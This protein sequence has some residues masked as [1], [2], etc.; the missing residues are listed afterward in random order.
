[1]QINSSTNGHAELTEAEVSSAALADEHPGVRRAVELVGQI[2]TGSVA[3]RGFNGF[4]HT[5]LGLSASDLACSERDLSSV[6]HVTVGLALAALIERYDPQIGPS[7]EHEAP[8]WGHVKIG[9]QQFT[10]PRCLA[11]YF[12]AGTMA[13][14]PMVVR[15]TS[16]RITGN[17]QLQVYTR[18]ADRAH[19]AAAIETI[20]TDADGP[21]NLFRNKALT[22]TAKY[23]GD[24][25]FQVADLPAVTRSDV[26]VPE[27]VW[28]E[29]DLNI[30]AVTTQRE[31]MT[32]LGMGL[33]RGV[34]LAG[35]PGVGKTAISQV[36]SQEMV[37]EFTVINVNSRAG[38]HALSDVYTEARAFGPSVIVLED[39]DLIVG[40]RRQRGDNS[41]L[42]EFLA[43]MDADPAAP[44]LTLAS[45]ND[46]TTL[47]AAAIRNARF[48]SIIEIGYPDRDAATQ[49]LATYLR[50]VPG[51]DNVDTRAVAATFSP[52]TSG[53][54]IREIVRR[55]V[56][57]DA[58]VSQD[59]L[60]AT[61]KSGRFK[62]Q[63]PEGSYL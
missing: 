36:V 57:A 1:M 41:T 32:R 25:V 50:G 46:V 26:I 47:D 13:A 11:A 18:P 24:C 39:L 44:I 3:S 58:T 35:P 19:S 54:D 30:A 7:D 12:A 28:S 20:M 22:A 63:L 2:L 14:A 21:K 45:T 55:T 49:I 61:V 33:R 34:L 52:T 59:S 23:D 16:G 40:D 37:G 15:L 43:A 10:P 48:D 62:P 6:G 56:L 5:A 60:L 29:I 51:G 8:T 38:Q 4:A 17:A 31:L 27:S 9:D 42:S 53:A